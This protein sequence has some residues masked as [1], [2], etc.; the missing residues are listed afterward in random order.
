MPL[1][2]ILHLIPIRNALLKRQNH[3]SSFVL[4]TIRR[5]T[6]R[7]S[8]TRSC[9]RGRPPAQGK[10]RQDRASS[11]EPPEH[12]S[13]HPQGG[14]DEKVQHSRRDDLWLDSHPRPVLCG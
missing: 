7:T 10:P 3:S 4:N 6:S 1:P 14:S 12:F 11:R 13:L 9:A 2:S 8:Q 5:T